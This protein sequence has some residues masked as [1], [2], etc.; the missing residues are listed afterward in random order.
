M[1]S[2]QLA[3]SRVN[4]EGVHVPISAVFFLIAFSWPNC[5]SNALVFRYYFIP[6]ETS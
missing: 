1:H 2:L 3:D 5:F 4:V 6:R